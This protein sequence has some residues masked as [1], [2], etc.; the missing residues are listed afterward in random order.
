MATRSWMRCALLSASF[1][2]ILHPSSFSLSLAGTVRTLDGKTYDGDVRLDT[3]GQIVITPPEGGTPKKIDLDEVLHATFGNEATQA[4]AKIAP[5]IRTENNQLPAPWSAT[6]VGA[7]SEKGYAK[8]TNEGQVFSVKSAGGNIGAADDDA[9]C[10]V[11]QP[12]TGDLE[13]SAR[14]TT[15]G[16]AKQVTQGLMIR[17]S[18][19]PGANY[20]AIFYVAGDLRFFK[21]TR[22]GQATDAG[23]IGAARS[24]LPVS[25]RLT[26]RGDTITAAWSRDGA[27]WQ[28]LGSEMLPMRPGALAGIACCG[29]GKQLLGAHVTNLRLTAIAPVTTADAAP[30][31]AAPQPT[32]EGL[33]LRSGTH[34]AAAQID[35]AN[36]AS[37]HFTKGDRNDTLSLAAV[38]RIIYRE[39]PPETVAKIPE[40]RAG[41]LLKEGDFVEGAFKGLQ[42]GRIHLSSVLFG[43]AKFDPREKAIALILNDLDPAARPKLIL[44]TRDGSTYVAKAVAPEKDKLIVEDPIAG[45]FTINRW[46]VTEISAGAGRLESLTT[47]KPEKV[48][49]PPQGD[50]PTLSINSTGLGLPMNLAGAPCQHGLTLTAGGAAT[51]NLA[52]RYRTFTFKCGVP[53]GILPTAPIRFIVLADGK[54]LYKSRPQT[55]LDDPCSSSLSVKVI[56]TLTLKVE[57]TTPNPLPTP[58]LWADPALVK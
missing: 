34:L 57:S 32:K 11:A 45:Q 50:I 33:T 46:E 31:S 14:T 58:G 4:A 44:R 41:V 53:Q 49:P 30:A 40:Q 15:I 48:D 21:R 25:M 28:P 16:D 17:A 47:L 19:D 5:A 55:S 13:L 24:P 56:T 12:V 38:A 29:R 10:F 18:A 54:E 37:L 20:I 26:R 27:T 51:W 36:D 52:G 1:C 23:T 9:F 35:K 22:T 8:Y 3:G 7:L 6:D 39:L 2:F 43:L 42:Q